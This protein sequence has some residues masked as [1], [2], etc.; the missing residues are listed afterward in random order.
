MGV[1]QF[2]K[3]DFVLNLIEKKNQL[4]QNINSF[5]QILAVNNNIG[6]RESLIDADG[7]PRNDI[8]VYQVRH[9][10]HQINTLQ[11]D[12]KSLMKEIEKGLEAFHAEST[13]NGP[14][15]PKAASFRSNS[16]DMEVVETPLYPF[17][18]VNFVSPGSPA[19][20]AGIRFNDE[21]IEFGS[22]NASNFRELTQISE[23]VKHRQNERIPIRVQRDNKVNELCL[24]PQTWSGRGL[25]GCNV[26]VIEGSSR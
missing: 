22:L 13:S 4:E 1:P 17:V 26:V 18:R 7:Y 12:L 2:S 25:L 23:I 20:A 21:I 16:D 5:G 11:N 3:K 10:R 9:A 19:E 6:M 24:V 8:D 15:G 14:S